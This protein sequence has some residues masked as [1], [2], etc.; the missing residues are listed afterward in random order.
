MII[1]GSRSEV[2]SNVTK[3]NAKLFPRYKYLTGFPSTLL[4]PPLGTTQDCVLVQIAMDKQQGQTTACT[5]GTSR[6]NDLASQPSRFTKKEKWFIV[7][8]TSFVGLFRQLLSCLKLELFLTDPIAL[9]SFNGWYLPPSNPYPCN[10]IP[11]VYRAH[12]SFCK[13]TLLPLKLA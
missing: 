12:Q 7:G 4:S 1:I 6:S 3:S 9:Q 10:C 5:P 2:K 11:Q 8:F 13:I